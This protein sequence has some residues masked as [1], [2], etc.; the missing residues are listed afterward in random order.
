MKSAPPE[1]DNLDRR[2]LRKYQKNTRIAA[3]KIAADVGL[4][5]A[6]V[7]RRLRRL[8]KIGVITAEIAVLAPE[9]IGLAVTCLVGVELIRE[10]AGASSRFKARMSRHPQV[11]QCY[12]ITGALDYMLVVLSRDLASFDLFTRK[13]LL[14]DPNVRSFTTYVVLDRVKTDPTLPIDVSGNP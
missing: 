3:G 12:D 8:R 1:L 7:Q 4:S 11:Q 10:T 9:A 5:T 13:T 14:E 2:I 6:A